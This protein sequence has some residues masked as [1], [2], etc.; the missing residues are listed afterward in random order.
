MQILCLVRGLGGESNGV[1]Q[2]LA[3]LGK[4]FCLDRFTTTINLYVE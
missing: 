4:C 2:K 1:P 3:M